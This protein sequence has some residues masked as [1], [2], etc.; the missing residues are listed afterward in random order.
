MKLHSAYLC[1]SGPFRVLVFRVFSV[2]LG[3]K[4]KA[5]SRVTCTS[6]RVCGENTARAQNSFRLIRIAKHDVFFDA[7]YYTFRLFIIIFLFVFFWKV[8]EDDETNPSS[9]F[10]DDANE[11]GYE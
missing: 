9:R 8:C 11:S 2:S 5:R 1:R 10:H 6:S 4:K 7:L 3:E